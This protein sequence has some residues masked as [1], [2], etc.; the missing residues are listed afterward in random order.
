MIKTKLMTA[1][2]LA[3][4]LGTS[5]VTFA[6]DVDADV[7]RDA[8]VTAE[9]PAKGAGA[10][11]DASTAADTQ[12]KD[13][14]AWDNSYEGVSQSFEEAAKL[15]LSAIDSDTEI[16]ITTISSLEGDAAAGQDMLDAYL[17]GHA[18]EQKGLYERISKNDAL[19]SKLED[20]GY[21]VEDVISLKQ[22]EDG[23]V[24]VYVDDRPE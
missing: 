16:T 13:M 2:S 9:V 18:D 23:S 3:T 5:P 12:A 22:N 17:S 11:A 20:E 14:A 6:Q 1:I 10:E 21:K 8:G 19:T 4:L 15:D 7:T 24:L